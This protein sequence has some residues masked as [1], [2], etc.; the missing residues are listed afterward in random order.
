MHLHKDSNSQ[1]DITMYFIGYIMNKLQSKLD[2]CHCSKTNLY[3]S[4]GKQFSTCQRERLLLM[5]SLNITRYLYVISQVNCRANYVFV[6][7]SA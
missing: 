4:S 2:A 7:V 1:L 3:Y 5:H 6:V